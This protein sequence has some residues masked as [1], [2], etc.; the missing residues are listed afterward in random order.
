MKRDKVTVFNRQYETL[1]FE[2]VEETNSF[3]EYG[4]NA[5][6]WGVIHSEENL[7]HIARIEDKGLFLNPSMM[8]VLK[9]T[10]FSHDCQIWFL[11]I[12]QNECRLHSLEEIK[13]RSIEDTKKNLETLLGARFTSGCVTYLQTKAI[14]AA[15]HGVERILPKF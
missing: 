13:G 3:L 4:D 6:I 12:L 14:A 9:L 7:H 10:K 15:V 1:S 2:T 8:E 5:K 11:G